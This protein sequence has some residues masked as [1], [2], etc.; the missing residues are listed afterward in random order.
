MDRQQTCKRCSIA[1]VN[2]LCYLYEKAFEENES[3]S[4]NNL[5]TLVQLAQSRGHPNGRQILRPKL[6]RSQVRTLAWNI[7]SLLYNNDMLRLGISLNG[8]ERT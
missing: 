2:A 5:K 6:R 3:Q 7:S 8:R 1:R 4:L